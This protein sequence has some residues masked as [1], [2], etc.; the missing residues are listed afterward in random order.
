MDGTTGAVACDGS[1]GILAALPMPLGSLIEPFWPFTLPGPSGMP[2]TP[3]SWA[4]VRNGAARVRTIMPANAN[5][6]IIRPREKT[7]A[8]LIDMIP[9]RAVGSTGR[10][11]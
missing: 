8:R 6:P 7:E 3:A 2:L 10:T 11:L 1:G 5:L 4:S 9:S